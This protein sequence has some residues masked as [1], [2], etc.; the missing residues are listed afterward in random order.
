MFRRGMEWLDLVWF[1]VHG[2]FS[3]V[4]ARLVLWRGQNRLD[5]CS[6]QSSTAAKG[7]GWHGSTC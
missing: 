5:R 2:L 7:G 3:N 4:G 1:I 6:N